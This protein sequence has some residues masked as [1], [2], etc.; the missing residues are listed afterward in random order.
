MLSL[1]LCWKKELDADAMDTRVQALLDHHDCPWSDPRASEFGLEARDTLF[2]QIY[3]LDRLLLRCSEDKERYVQTVKLARP[4]HSHAII[5]DKK[6][7][8]DVTIVAC[9]WVCGSRSVRLALPGFVCLFV[10]GAACFQISQRD[11]CRRLLARS[12]TS[13]N[14]MYFE[15]EYYESSISAP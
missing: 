9:A 3:H 8:T 5:S 14:F 2:G 1:L 12:A 7:L 4:H 13:S 15:N 11:L 6:P 10:R